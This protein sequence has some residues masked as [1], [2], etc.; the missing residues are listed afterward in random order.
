[1][2]GYTRRVAGITWAA[3]AFSYHDE[4]LTGPV[5]YLANPLDMNND[6][7]KATAKEGDGMSKA[8]LTVTVF[9]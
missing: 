6:F 5:T 9:L 3:V 8:I 7:H 1:L 2:T 4:G